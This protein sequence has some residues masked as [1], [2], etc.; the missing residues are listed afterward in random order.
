[1]FPGPGEFKL[2]IVGGRDSKSC[3]EYHNI[4]E[5]TLL[6]K[7]NMLANF[8]RHSFGFCSIEKDS[9]LLV[10]SGIKDGMISS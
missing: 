8:E 9:K 10:A 4:Y 5:G 2:L 3:Y 7:K 6:Q 1:L